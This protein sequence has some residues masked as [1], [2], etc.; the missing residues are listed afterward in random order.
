MKTSEILIKAKA[1]IS[2]P[3]K[4]TQGAFARNYDGEEVSPISSQAVCFCSIGALKASVGKDQSEV[5]MF[6]LVN[7]RDYLMK[8]TPDGYIAVF[9]DEHTHEEVMA[10]WDKAIKLAK[11]SGA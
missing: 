2:N 10:V 3:D 11:L 7:A 4:W 1:I 5:T 6:Y 9:N 8:A